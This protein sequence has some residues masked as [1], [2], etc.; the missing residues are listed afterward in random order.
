[1]LVRRAM[2]DPDAKPAKSKIVDVADY[3]IRNALR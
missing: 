1:M 2:D 3:L